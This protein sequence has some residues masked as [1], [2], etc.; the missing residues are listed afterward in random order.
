VRYSILSLGVICIIF[1]S[2]NKPSNNNSSG[3]PYDGLW[4]LQ[5]LEIGCGTSL[6]QDLIVTLGAFSTNTFSISCTPILAY[7]FYISGNINSS[8][9][10]SGSL[11]SSNYA[12][13]PCPFTGNCSSP[14]SCSASGSAPGSSI[15]VTVIR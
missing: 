7:T 4:K 10:F 15:V 14:D 12:S 1:L 3:T 13:V 8:G 11:Y 2:C 6:P 5:V 9:I